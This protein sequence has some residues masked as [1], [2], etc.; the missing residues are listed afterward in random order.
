MYAA[1]TGLVKKLDR[2][3]L[4][5]RPRLRAL[6]RGA[7]SGVT[8]HGEETEGADERGVHYMAEMNANGLN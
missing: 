3:R 1:V 2:I 6:T 8:T 7:E 4:D 5:E